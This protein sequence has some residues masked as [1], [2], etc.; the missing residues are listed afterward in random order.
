MTAPR[1]RVWFTAAGTNNARGT[2][3][4]Q[5]LNIPDGTIQRLIGTVLFETLDDPPP[6]SLFVGM[7]WGFNVG[8]TAMDAVIGGVDPEGVMIRK[9]L[10]APPAGSAVAR[11]PLPE[12][13][14]D[15][16]GQRIVADPAAL[17]FSAATVDPAVTWLFAYEVRVL[18]LLP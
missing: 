3:F 5:N 16:D 11:S 4:T 6:G 13:S 7:G 1:E 12:Q 15:I 8:A 17:W 18:I 10:I 2:A 14:F 9:I